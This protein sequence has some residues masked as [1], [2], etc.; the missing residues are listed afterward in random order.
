MAEELFT[1]AELLQRLKGKIGRTKLVQHI[2]AVPQFAGGPTHRKI[3][4]KYL[5]TEADIGRIIDSLACPENTASSLTTSNFGK[6]RVLAAPSEQRAYDRAM[7]LLSKA[8][9]KPTR[10]TTKQGK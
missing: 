8:M 3:G 7:K 5:F 6:E 4:A 9:Q 2:N 10:R 1:L